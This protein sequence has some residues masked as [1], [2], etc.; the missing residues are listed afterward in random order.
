METLRRLLRGGLS[1]LLF[2]AGLEL[3]GAAADFERI[4]L[5]QGLSQ[6]VIE[7]IVQD[8]KGFLWFATED[9]LNRYD[10]YGFTV[11]R[12]QA[13]NPRSLSYNDIKT[14]HEDRA[15]LLWV[16]TFEGGLNRF[17]PAAG[18][19]TRYRND[20]ADPSSL[21]ANTVR[22]ILEDRAG[23]LWLGTQGGGLD[24][25]DRATGRFAHLRF[26]PSDPSS[27][28]HDDVRA[29][30]EDRSG[31]LWIGTYGGG[32]ARYDREKGTFTRYR[33]DPADPQSLSHDLV[34]ALFEDRRGTLWVG[35]YGGGVNAFDR[36]TGACRRYRAA[37]PGTLPNDLVRAIFEGDSG[38]LW[39]A[40]DG[41]G[42]ARLEGDTGAV[43]SWRTDALSPRSLS[44]DRVWSLLEDSSGILWIGTYGGG[45]NK[46]AVKRKKFAH[47]R[48]EPGNRSS[49]NHNIVWSIR[50][51]RDGVLWIGTDAGGLN[52]LDR[53]TGKARFWLHD[54][55]DPRSLSHD[56]V[57]VV[58][59][60]RSGTLWLGTNG[61]GVNRFDP[62]TETFQRFR[63]DPADPGSLSHDEI[64]TIYED[65]AGNLWIGTYGGGLERLD[66]RSGRFVHHRVESGNPRS[67]PSDF[68]RTIL[69]DA[70]G[71]LWIG[72][73]GGGLAR[74]DPAT[75][76]FSSFRA[77][78]A[79]PGSLSND[80]VFVVHEDR[81]GAL[82]VATFGGGLNRLDRATGRFT[83][84][85]E[86][87]GLASDSIYG[88]LEDETGRLWISTTRGLSCFD[89]RASSFHNYDVRDGLQSNEFNGGS[90]YRSARG[91][92]FFGGINGFNS[93][94]PAEIVL[95]RRP[96][97][98]AFTDLMLFNRSVR[99]GEAVHGRVILERPLAYTDAVTLSW[100]EAVIAVEFAALHY[101]APEKNQ[102]AYLLEGFNQTW[103]P[104]RADRRIATFTGLPPGHYV[105]RVRA[106]NGDGIWN[107]DGATLRI[108]VT[109]PVWATWWFR[110]AVLALLAGLVAAGLRRRLRNVRL[111]AA[112]KAAHEAQMALLP[113]GDPSIR[114]FEV[115]GT[116]LPTYEV[117]G[118]FYDYL[119]PNG[120]D[121][122]LWIA[123]GDVSGKGVRAAMTAAMSSGMVRAHAGGDA[124]LAG[125]VTA[126]SRAL[127]GKI[128]RHMFTALCL[129]A[130][131][132]RT[133]EMTIV[134][135]G[136]CEPLR[137]S[138]GSVEFLE[139][140]APSFPLGAFPSTVYR[141]R[142]VTLRPGDVVVFYTDG[143]PEALDRHG[144]QYGY[145][146]LASLVK[147]L[148]TA[149]LSAR[150]IRD[151]IVREVGRFSG[152]SRLQDDVA[153]VVVKAV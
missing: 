34:T 6:S 77:D 153:L 141:S 95:D 142:T 150:E 122:D 145:E 25:L 143:V 126:V 13:G 15:G 146:A 12:Y 111:A 117:G 147:G 87:D 130:L 20:P 59:F 33:Y 45:L 103:I 88:L 72:T 100:R 144:T 61:G 39:I 98:V 52:R 23:N 67:L 68:V 102:Y 2:G 36:S 27:L 69:E 14:L 35:T 42:L 125:V 53:R 74:R 56:A 109:P 10:G 90:F 65:R 106:A 22:A 93:F 89:P 120:E 115:T 8:R 26:D 135:A 82:W 70:A 66:R 81:A 73:N 49:I 71:T 62:A 121:A 60:D 104:A 99:V 75:G 58:F 137:R 134:N 17:D 16:G 138:D 110:L 118:D 86:A 152:G 79:D 48:S 3:S 85:T 43:E 96:P 149:A 129:A 54:P 119:R 50:E 1:L 123:V 21:A 32:L 101:A 124:S 108:T 83:R 29:I 84:F 148:D 38:A 94:F 4:S 127:H 112:L 113:Q 19:F 132:G 136:L 97:R 51:D 28:P 80:V 114:G 116:C 46:L 24:R 57:R 44:T 140:L 18:V 151:A 76:A 128:E 105:L 91:E 92:M 11:Y 31:T 30:L 40:T 47:V 9:G 107:E 133:H 78:P 5:E 7:S 139:S 41:G 131:D 64:R 37:G 55:R 63:H